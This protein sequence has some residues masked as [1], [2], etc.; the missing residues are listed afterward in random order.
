MKRAIYFSSGFVLFVALCVLWLPWLGETLFYSKGE[1]REAVVAMSML[2][3]GDWVLPVSCGSDI[4]YKPPFLAWLIASLAWLLNGGVVNEYIAR[5]PS[6]LAAIALVMGSYAWV[7]KIRGEQFALFMALI[8][9][10]SVEFYRAATACRVDMVLTACMVGAI[11]MLFEVRQHRGRDNFW[12]YAVA[13]LLLTCGVLTKGPIGAFLPCL[14]AGVYLVFHGDRFFP[15]LGRMAALCFAACVVPA[16]WYYY[17][18]LEGGRHFVE[19]A[20]EE[21]FGRLTGTM[22]YSSHEKPFWYNFVTFIVGMLP[23]TLLVLMASGALRR[24]MQRP[25]KPAGLLAVTAVLVVVGFYCIPSSKRSV[26]LLPAYPFMAYGVAS[27]AET[28]AETRINSAFT[29]VLAIIAIALPA[30]AVLT[31]WVPLG[32]FSFSAAGWWAWPLLALPAAVAIGWLMQAMPRGNIGGAVLIVWGILT[33]YGGALMPAALNRFSARDDAATVAA[34][35]GPAGKIYTVGRP[36]AAPSYCLNY[37]L[38]D[39]MERIA[40]AAEAAKAPRGT[41]LVFPD[42]ADTVGLPPAY[43][44]SLLTD[45]SAD[46]RHPMLIAVKQR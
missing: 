22:S 18:W 6:A 27:M 9:A 25:F 42:R 26:Y 46:T 24:L 33:C 41:V 23:W 39:R 43:H 2:A 36:E 11:Y 16:I 30:V 7:R 29:R 8:L 34:L 20:W 17:A 21:N 40:T 35:A 19:L 28:L 37:Y 32:G 31:I 45:R 4:P 38:G 1:P 12:R 14:V 15:T 44:L 3:S 13:T 5:L 10:G